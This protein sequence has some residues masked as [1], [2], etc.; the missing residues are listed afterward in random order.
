[1]PLRRITLGRLLEEEVVNAHPA[2]RD[3]AVIGVPNDV[4]EHDVAVF[5]VRH[6]GTSVEPEEIRA[7]CQGK[8]AHYI[9]FPTGDDNH[10]QGFSSH[11][12]LMK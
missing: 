4:N 5:V 2:V 12:G 7:H 10:Q 3:C 8:L 1:M 6:P 11:R 9:V